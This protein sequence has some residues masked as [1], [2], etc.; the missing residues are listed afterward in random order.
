MKF[1]ILCSVE[2]GF[3]VFTKSKIKLFQKIKQKGI[4]KGQVAIISAFGFVAFVGFMGLVVDGGHLYVEH[5][6]LQNASDL[7][8]IAGTWAYYEVEYKGC[9]TAT[10]TTCTGSAT[11]PNGLAG[12]QNAEAEAQKAGDRTLVQN[13][14]P[15]LSVE[16]DFMDVHN[17]KLNGGQTVPSPCTSTLTCTSSPNTDACINSGTGTGCPGPAD[18]RE[19]QVTMTSAGIPTYFLNLFGVHTSTVSGGSTAAMGPPQG[20][21]KEGPVILINYSG[22]TFNIPRNS[23]YGSGAAQCYPNPGDGIY[24]PSI[25]DCRPKTTPS[26]WPSPNIGQVQ[27]R[28]EYEG[29]FTPASTYAA[30]FNTAPIIQ[31]YVMH[32]NPSCPTAT[33]NT[34]DCTMDSSTAKTGLQQPI[35]NCPPTNPTNPSSPPPSTCS[36]SYAYYGALSYIVGGTTGGWSHQCAGTSCGPSYP[37]PRSYPAMAYDGE[38]AIS[39]SVIFGGFS[40]TYTDLQDMWQYKLSSVNGSGT[41]TQITP[42]ACSSAHGSCSGPG[43]LYPPARSNAGMVYDAATN[44]LVLFGG[45]QSSTSKF[46][47]DTWTWTSTAGWVEK[48]P[49]GS[50]GYPCNSGCP[51]PLWFPSMAYDT[52]NSNVILFGGLNAAYAYRGNTW[53]WNGSGWTQMCAGAQPACTTALPPRWEAGFAYGVAGGIVLYGGDNGTTGFL[54]D[55]YVWNGTTNTDRKSTRLNSSHANIS[56]AVFC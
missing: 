28:P 22:P 55:M 34:P 8:S 43:S 47:N 32:N 51:E 54:S 45:Y 25:P 30:P 3:L 29:A 9:L 10:S 50:S 23:S 33:P 39:A 38:P 21:T 26:S 24:Y 31:Y 6:K 11:Y 37:V 46:L 2:K 15:N 12:V 14:Y 56:Y 36:S 5:R 53:K 27:L 16:L 19:V 44:S 35:L 17:V 42:V 1:W 20:S 49:T 41:W 40:A 4:Q 13:G 48:D 18:V 52:G 7:A